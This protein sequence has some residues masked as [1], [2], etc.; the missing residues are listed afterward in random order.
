MK[1][2]VIELFDLFHLMLIGT[3]VI[4]FRLFLN[5]EDYNEYVR[6]RVNR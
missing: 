5:K 2:F 3:E 6:E 1:K 4:I